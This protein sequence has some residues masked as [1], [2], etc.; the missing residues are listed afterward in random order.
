MGIGPL[1]KFLDGVDFASVCSAGLYRLAQSDTLI[2][3]NAFI[4]SMVEVEEVGD[5]VAF[6]DKSVRDTVAAIADVPPN[7]PG[8]DPDD[9]GDGGREGGRG[10]GDA[11]PDDD[12]GVEPLPLW[13]RVFDEAVE[14]AR[15]ARTM[16]LLAESDEECDGAPHADG[17]VASGPDGPHVAPEALVV[18]PAPPLP[19]PPPP[20]PEPPGREGSGLSRPEGEVR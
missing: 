19:S 3:D 18:A 6:W 10:R 2:D 1:E 4:P 20:H 14:R 5:A 15:I 7:D 9:G 13:M 11:P 8:P 12:D 17:D 16:G